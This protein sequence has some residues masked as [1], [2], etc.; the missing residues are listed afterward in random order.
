MTADHIQYSHAPLK[1]ASSA[2]ILRLMERV[3]G[4]QAVVVSTEDGFEVAAYAENKAQTRRLA[5]MASSLAALCDV[6]G[7]ESQLGPCDNITISAA[8]GHIVLLRIPRLD[9]PLTLSVVARKDTVIG[10]VLYF[11]RITVKELALA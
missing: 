10:Q 9:L 4:L 11:A 5:A 6:A 2:A 1:I 3:R 8:D 7:E